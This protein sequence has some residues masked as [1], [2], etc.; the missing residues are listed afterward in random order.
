MK[1]EEAADVVFIQRLRMVQMQPY[2][3]GTQSC[4]VPSRH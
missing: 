2:I 1:G 3:C 4:M